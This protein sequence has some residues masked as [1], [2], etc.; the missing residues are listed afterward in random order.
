M[1]LPIIFLL[2]ALLSSPL[3]ANDCPELLR[4]KH[5]QLRSE[6]TVDFCERFSGRLLLVVNTASRCGYTPQ[7]K[8]LE[9]LYQRYRERGLEIVGF[10]SNDFRQ[11][12]REA[13]KTAEVC[14]VNYGV[15]FTMLESSAV[16]GANANAFFGALAAA[17]AEVP[18]WNFYKTLIDRRGRILASF[19]SQ[20]APDDPALVE[21]IE[22]QLR[23]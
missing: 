18:R 10:P 4:Y 7:F 2:L 11:E 13:D 21:L 1:R 16:V 5:P 19:P 6:H 15:T 8:Q 14:Y 9:T 3:L 20:T 23:P 22:Q 12:Y 17:G